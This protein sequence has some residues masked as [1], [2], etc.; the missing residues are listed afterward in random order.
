MLKMAT[1][2]VETD[3]D[4]VHTPAPVPR[5]GLVINAILSM[6]TIGVLAVCLGKWLL[7]LA[8]CLRLINPRARRVANT[9]DWRSVPITRWRKSFSQSNSM[10]GLT[11]IYQVIFAI[12][13]DSILFIIATNILADGFGVNLNQ[14]VC[15]S[16]I[17]LCITCYLST[18][19]CILR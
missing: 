14:G 8:S 6:V 10:S 15:S 7:H 4:G 18:K 19:V 5:V 1:R 2:A 3:V 16:T 11:K 13:I 12:Y 9:V 17:L